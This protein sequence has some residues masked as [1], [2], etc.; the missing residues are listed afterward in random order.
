MGKGDTSIS[1]IMYT[2]MSLLFLLLGVVLLV[3]ILMSTINPY[4][5]VAFANVEKLR[6]G[7]DEACFTENEVKID[8]FELPQNTPK[9]TSLVPVM[10]IWIIRTN[11]DPNYVLYYEAFPA[12]D[13]TGW[14]VYQGL[15]NRLLA[16]LPSGY[17]DGKK[18]EP[19]VRTYV[20]QV[21]EL[22]RTNSMPVTLISKNLHGVIINN[23]ILGKTRPDYFIGQQDSLSPAVDFGPQTGNKIEK[24]GQ[25]R[26]LQNPDPENPIPSEGDNAF[27]FQNYKGLTSFEKSA[28]KYE[29][30]GDNSLCLKTRTGVYKFPLRQCDGIKYIEMKYDAR[31]RKAVYGAAGV[32]LVAVGAGAC[33][34][35]TGG[36]CI[37]IVGSA[38]EIAGGTAAITGAV[39]I[40]GPS[41]AVVSTVT[42]V[43]TEIVAGTLVAK[44]ASGILI[45]VV[46]ETSG[47]TATALTTPAAV[48]A[49]GTTLG[50]VLSSLGSASWYLA[51]GG[52]RLLWKA[53][54]IVPGLRS[55]LTVGAGATAL[56]GTG[57]AGYKLTE[58][59]GGA[60]LSYKVQDFNI[61]SSCSLKDVR[62]TKVDCDKLECSQAVSY[63]I[64]KY[65]GDGKLTQRD[66][67]NHE[68]THYTCLEKIGTDIQDPAGTGFDGGKCLQ[69]VVEE[70]AGGFCWTPDPYR[71]SWI[72]DTQL[73]A[74]HLEM[75]PIH[76]NTAYIKGSAG[77]AAVLKY[78]PQGALET[79]KEFFGRRLTWAWPG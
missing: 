56:G 79:W 67:N 1:E 61:E 62:I 40:L 57:V 76:D 32:T 7:M 26:D 24:F 65:G 49:S 53:A 16:P 46:I 72:S 22:W 55:I 51:K 73:L 50:S 41:G 36:G 9:F 60:F 39:N 17:D 18:G 69:V 71:D 48:A 33:I 20:G 58:F 30:C 78:Y 37:P 59:I 42:G 64:Y 31:N 21:K 15:D 6:A 25:W 11:G 34:V 35:L 27:L 54:G 13:A 23:I 19:D 14:E 29:P 4:D 28:V 3:S 63:P 52:A 43:S 12:G 5:Q 2:M 47:A 70:K 44:T 74:R 8:T 38:G 66:L 75:V 45:P 68:M 10:P 77:D